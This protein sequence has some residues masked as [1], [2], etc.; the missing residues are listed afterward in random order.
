LAIA[1]AIPTLRCPSSGLKRRL[2]LKTG[3]FQS[4]QFPWG[5]VLFQ[6]LSLFS[7]LFSI[8]VGVASLTLVLASLF[9]V[10]GILNI[11][12]FFKVRSVQGSR[13]FLIDGIITLLLGLMIY[14]QW[15]SSSAWAI[16]TLGRREHDHE[17]RYAGDAIAGGAQGNGHDCVEVRCGV[18][19]REKNRVSRRKNARTDKAGRIHGRPRHR[20]QRLHL[21][22]PRTANR[23]SLT[24]RELFLREQAHYPVSPF[25]RCGTLMREANAANQ[26]SKTS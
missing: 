8:A 2:P 16:G 19:L 4:V 25:Q 15:P 10:E 5:E 9:L 20:H 17:R 22:L 24:K 21:R 11:A 7:F 26:V 23:Q 3:I 13:W 14:A 12:L 6:R 1:F 18:R